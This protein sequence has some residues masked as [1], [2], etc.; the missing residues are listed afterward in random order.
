MLLS[1]M[2]G[3]KYPIIGGAMANISDAKFAAAVSNAG[4]LGI[5]ATA[6]MTPEEVENEIL[7]CKELTDKPFGV[8]LM[9]M[10]PQTPLI[11][12]VVCKH[13]V[14]MVTM[15]AGNGGVY[16]KQLQEAG[17]KIFPVVAHGGL[18]KRLAR[19]NV[20]GFIVEGTE[21]GGHVGESTTMALVP[22]II[23]LTNKPVVAAGGIASGRQLNAS[24]ALGAIGVQVGTIL[25][26]STECPIHENYKQAV[27]QAKDSDT[28][29]TGRS[30]NAPVRILK[31]KM[32]KKY[33]ELENIAKD[34]LEL[35]NMTLGAFRKAIYDG[36][37]ENGSVMMGQ[38][39]GMCNKILP[40]ADIFAKMISDAKLEQE[41]LVNKIMSL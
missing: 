27:I 26:T 31:N 35:E 10:N 22:Q 23:D 38:V 34:V 40:I 14:C 6:V 7:K 24:L 11:V 16:I 2:L 9:L 25:L 39:A 30:K 29:V 33:I 36:D 21:S 20:D 15:G 1:E 37:I 41:L 13:K 12:D 17:I 32:S 19:A 5:I 8:N 4:G 3:I 28:V 18:A